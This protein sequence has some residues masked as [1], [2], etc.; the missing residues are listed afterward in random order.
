MKAFEVEE[1]KEKKE[2]KIVNATDRMFPLRNQ[3]PTLVI[4]RQSFPANNNNNNNNSGACLAKII[5]FGC[6][7]KKLFTLDITQLYEMIWH[8]SMCL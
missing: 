5:K 6:L 2:L 8:S 7:T 1:E 3:A 4:L